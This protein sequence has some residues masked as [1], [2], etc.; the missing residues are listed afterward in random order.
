MSLNVSD[1]LSLYQLMCGLNTNL[2]R[3]VRTV[4]TVKPSGSRR[5]YGF[6]YRELIDEPGRGSCMKELD[7]GLSSKVWIEIANT[8]D[9]VLVCAGL[10]DAITATDKPV[11]WNQQCGKVP[12]GQDYL[13]ATTS[14]LKAIF[15]R[16]SGA[17]NNTLAARQLKISDEWRWNV[18]ESPFLFCSH[19]GSHGSGDCWKNTRMIQHLDPQP[20]LLRKLLGI[21]AKPASTSITI[22]DS[23]AVVFGAL[24][25]VPNT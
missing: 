5:L 13:T 17:L 6:E 23:G 11:K 16:K 14:C 7:L 12:Q 22:T 9:V 25:M 19:H 1:R 4:R 10:G 21:Y 2:L 24:S 20:S 8:A 18:F 15:E 3:T